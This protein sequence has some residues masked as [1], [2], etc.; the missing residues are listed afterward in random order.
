MADVVTFE[1]AVS[2]FDESL[3]SSGSDLFNTYLN[4]RLLLLLRKN[5][6]AGCSTWNNEMVDTTVDMVDTMV[7]TTVD[8]VDTTVDMVDT[9]VDTTVD[10]VDTTVDMVD[11]TVGT[12]VDMEIRNNKRP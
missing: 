12:T 2:R 5:M 7:D 1:E 8:M 9:M 6:K 3:L 10:M 4:N 11:T